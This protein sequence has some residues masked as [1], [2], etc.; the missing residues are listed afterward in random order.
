MKVK[1]TPAKYYNLDFQRGKTTDCVPYVTPTA[2][3]KVI[4]NRQAEGWV[5]TCVTA[6]R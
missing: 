5:L 6:V 1:T 3:V 2:V 4:Q